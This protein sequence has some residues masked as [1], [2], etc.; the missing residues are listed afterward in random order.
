MDGDMNGDDKTDNKDNGENEVDGDDYSNIYIFFL[1]AR[2]IT[3][4][5]Q[6]R[7]ITR[8]L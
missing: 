1:L 8:H 2:T 3:P 4:K 5:Q 7:Y 6:I